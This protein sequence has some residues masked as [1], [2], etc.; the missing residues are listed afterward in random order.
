MPRSDPKNTILNSQDHMSPLKPN[1]PTPAGSG[2]ANIAEAQ[3]TFLK[4]PCTRMVEVFKE[5]MD[6]ILKEIKTQTVQG[7]E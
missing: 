2:Y 1:N 7:K 5:A 6:K 4:T 3:E